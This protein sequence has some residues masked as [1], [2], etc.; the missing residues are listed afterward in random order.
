[1]TTPI[2]AILNATGNEVTGYPAFGSTGWGCALEMVI[3]GTDDPDAPNAKH[4]V[5]LT[6]WGTPA[7]PPLTDGL[8]ILVGQIRPPG[9]AVEM[10]SVE[11]DITPPWA[12]MAEFARGPVATM[13]TCNCIYHPDLANWYYAPDNINDAVSLLNQCLQRE[14]RE[15]RLTIPHD[16]NNW[17]GYAFKAQVN[18]L[19]IAIPMNDIMNIDLELRLTGDITTDHRG[20][21]YSKGSKGL[22][23]WTA[24]IYHPIAK[25]TPPADYI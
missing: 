5:Q 10:I 25:T 7:I 2:P 23:P 18:R 22:S 4:R 20:D 14:T 24:E 17:F 9:I 1:M 16:H 15:F 13:L 11:E 19:R 6:P 3:T 21:T 8:Y 12:D